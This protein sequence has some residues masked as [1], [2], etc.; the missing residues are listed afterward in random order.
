MRGVTA[1]DV[2]VT[3]LT[4]TAN[5]GIGVAGLARA[6]FVVANARA[7]DVRPSFVPLLGA[8]KGVGAIGLLIGLVGVH[9][10]GVA[11]AVGL[12]AFF[13]GAIAFH[14]R[15]RVIHTIAFPATFLVLAV[16]SLQVALD[17]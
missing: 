5:L 13:V 9:P 14:V 12:V 16:A 17:R 2:V 7:V 8:V 15:A 11:A 4:V 10:V 1:V 3:G 6:D